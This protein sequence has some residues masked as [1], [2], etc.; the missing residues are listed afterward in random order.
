MVEAIVL[1]QVKP[2]A[3]WAV[4]QAIDEIDGVTEA[5][6][7]AG[8]YDVIARAEADTLEEL[9]PSIVSNIQAVDGVTRTLTCP[10]L[11]L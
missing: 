2:G 9:G 4:A 5:V 6:A 8:P 7:V 1:V 11:S 3:S 10:V